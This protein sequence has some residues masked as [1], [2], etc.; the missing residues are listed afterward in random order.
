MLSFFSS[1]RSG[2]ME[3]PQGLHV[4][5][6]GDSD[7]RFT[8]LPSRALRNSWELCTVARVWAWTLWLGHVEC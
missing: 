5:G 1:S 4:K 6:V 8:L 2:S 3:A 7:G